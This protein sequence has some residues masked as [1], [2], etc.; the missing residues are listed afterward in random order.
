M[1]TAAGIFALASALTVS[2]AFASG[3]AQVPKNIDAIALRVSEQ[4][5]RKIPKDDF[6]E[7][8]Q[9]VKTIVVAQPSKSN[10][11]AFNAVQRE[12]MRRASVNAGLEK[13]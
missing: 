8:Y 7:L 9:A 1:K 3:M 11:D 13:E 10:Q 4:D 2:V 12:M 6:K 5:L